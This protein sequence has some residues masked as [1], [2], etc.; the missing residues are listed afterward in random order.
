MKERVRAAYVGYSQP[1]GP[2]PYAC[3]QMYTQIICT[4]TPMWQ[5]YAI[6]PWL[7][8]HQSRCQTLKV[9]H[10][11]QEAAGFHCV[12]GAAI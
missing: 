12:N 2:Q 9:G 10:A 6:M 11:L 5:P 7:L 1:M 4:A 8:F 3:P